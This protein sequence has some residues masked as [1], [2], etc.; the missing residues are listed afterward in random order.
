[1][2]DESHIEVINSQSTKKEDVDSAIGN[3]IAN[4][5]PGDCFLLYYS[6]PTKNDRI[7]LDSSTISNEEILAW[8]SQMSATKKIVLVDAANASL[9][10]AFIEDQNDNQRDF[11]SESITF[12]ISD[13]RVEMPEAEGGLFTSYLINGI[14]GGAAT[15][16]KNTYIEEV[17]QEQQIAYVT[18][19]SLEGYMY[20]TMS[21]GNLQFDLKSYSSGVDFPLTFINSA[22]FSVDTIPPMIYLPNVISSEGKRGGKTKRVTVKKSI[23][24]QALD[25]SGIAEITVNGQPVNFSQNGKFVLNEKFAKTWTKLVITAKDKRG[26]T[27]TDSFT[28]NLTEETYE[29]PTQ[30]EDEPVNYALLFA[31]SN[32][33]E[34]SNLENPK[35]DVT[36]IAELLEKSYGFKVQVVEDATKHEM[37]TVLLSY[38][39]K[40]YGPKDQLFVFFAG[41]GHYD[42]YNRGYVVA[43]NSKLDDPTMSSYLRFKQITDDLNDMYNCRHIFIA[44]DVCFGGKAFDKTGVT[45]YSGSTLEDIL[46]KP[47]YF[48]E[49]T[50][51][52]KSRI[53]MTSGSVEYVPDESLFAMKFVETL[54][55]KGAAKN[56]ILTLDDF[57]DNLKSL[58]L[59]TAKV[60]T[61]PRYGTFGD[62]EP[63]GD[64]LFIYSNTS[65]PKSDGM[66]KTQ[67]LAEKKQ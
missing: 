14:N 27:A 4:S 49:S 1:V 50:L 39:Q 11:T 13:G 56:G 35:K 16:W 38:M 64:F 48:I 47:Q 9:V 66:T 65:T 63:F 26:N 20:G 17:N 18:S 12:L 33:S 57:T 37:E 23:N 2:F 62:H 5:L 25:E 53:F 60:P 22:T 34:W 55:S 44:L 6:G 42:L 32:Y 15:S 46:K 36:T 7:L 43:S 67:T 30:N 10:P 61:T 45:N 28:V 54:R 40:S 21:S 41:H 3:V 8:L 31:T 51:E 19:K 59:P 29:D 52:I 58:T 24:G